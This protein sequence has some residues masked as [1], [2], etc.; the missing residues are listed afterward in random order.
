MMLQAALQLLLPAPAATAAL[1]RGGA[2]VGLLLLVASDIVPGCAAVGA[3]KPPGRNW[4]LLLR[5]H[6]G[7]FGTAIGHASRV[8]ECLRSRVRLGE[9]SLVCRRGRR[10]PVPELAEPAPL[11]VRAEAAVAARQ[12]LRWQL[13]AAEHTEARRR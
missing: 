8:P 13:R 11:A 1:L 5:A 12:R 3:W 9:A 10:G 6:N 4:V 7:A 2:L